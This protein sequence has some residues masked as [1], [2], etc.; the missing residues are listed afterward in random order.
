VQ[1]TITLSLHLVVLRIQREIAMAAIVA[2]E[3]IMVEVV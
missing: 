1:T 3:V 2:M